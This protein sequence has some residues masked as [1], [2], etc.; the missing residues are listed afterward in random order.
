MFLRSLFA[1][2]TLLLLGGCQGWIA[3]TRLIPVSERDPIGLEGTYVSDEGKVTIT[4][5]QDGLVVFYT[6]K[7]DPPK[8]ELAFDLL[9]EE[10]EPLD[11]ALPAEPAEGEAPPE[12]DR[13]YL[14]ESP[15]NTEDGVT[16][17]YY[18]IVRI[19]RSPDGADASLALFALRCSKSTAAFA[20]QREGD[21][22]GFDDYTRLR[23]AAFDALAWY[24]DARMPV[25]SRKIHLKRKRERKRSRR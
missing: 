12:P 16:G 9:R 6:K 20:A 19:S 10:A 7:D 15:I 1:A 5:G 23:A 8:Q 18:Q 25:E 3:E 11:Y 4:P 13:T 22:C 21:L 17:Y 2:A 14:F 24:D